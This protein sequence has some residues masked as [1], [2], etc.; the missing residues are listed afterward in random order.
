[1]KV[2]LLSNHYYRSKRRAGFHFVADALW[3]AGHEVLFVTTGISWISRAR[4]DNRTRY[5]ELMEGRNKLVEERPG[6]L[7]YVHFTPWHPHTLVL[8]PL[9]ALTRPF[10]GLY[11][12]FP[13]GAA[14]P[15]LKDAGL[16]IYESC[17]ALFLFERCRA[18]A[19]GAKHV[20][21]VS[22]DVRLLR[23]AHP[24]L[25]DLET[26]LAPEFDLVSVPCEY[27]AGKFSG[28]ARVEIHRHGVDRAPF[29]AAKASPYRGSPN[30]VFVGNAYLDRAFLKNAADSCP[31]VFFHAIGPLD[32]LPEAP[33][34]RAYGEIPFLETVPFIKFAD[35]GL[36]TL[37]LSHSAHAMS[38][39]DSL[40]VKQYRFCGL[41]VVAPAKL[42]VPGEGVFGYG[43]DPASCGEAVRAALASGR[44]LRRAEGVESWDEVA[45]RIIADAFVERQAD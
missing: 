14:E 32:K 18:L 7:S 9:D 19:S 27:L 24:A 30:C 31:D 12:G 15:L 39:T 45:A 43:D 40:K 42:G 41:P 33:N 20:Y 21:K 5:P 38:F 8:P 10:M 36:H 3:K 34:I 23:S 29:D 35:V 1:M 25:F 26:R 28:R 44:D 2:V 11:G 6:F 13:L 22:D 17:N 37:D 4:G 16:F